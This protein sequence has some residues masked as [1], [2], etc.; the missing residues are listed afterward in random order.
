M[1]TN[2]EARA[3]GSNTWSGPRAAAGGVLAALMA[4]QVVSRIFDL[5]AET[6]DWSYR[7]VMVGATVAVAMRAVRVREQRAA[8]AVI[9]VGLAAW[10]A[11]DLWYL[12]LLAGGDIPY[13]SPSDA[14]YLVLYGALI[15]GMRMLNGRAAFSFALIVVLLGLAT[16]WSGLVFSEVV[17]GAAGGTTAV[18]TTL[19]Y[20][21]L[22]LVLVVA[23]LLA[24]AARGGRPGRVLGALA[25]GF[26]LMALADSAF[27]V[28]VA[29]GTHQDGTLLEPLWPAS[30]LCIAA[31][32][33]MDA[34]RDNREATEGNHVVEV[35]TG[36][37]IAVGVA[38]LALDHFLEV[39]EVTVGLAAITLIAAVAQHAVIQRDRAE[40]RAAVAAAEKLRGASAEAALDCIISIDGAGR[41][42]EWNGAAART[43][44]YSREDAVGVD[45]AQL[46]IPLEHREQH[47]RG[48]R[49][50]A[51]TGEGRML[52]SQIE[53]T[54]MHAEG[55]TFPVELMITQVRVDPP[56][57]TGFLR[58]I[59]DRR[60]R[61]G[62]NERLA[63]IVRSS[64]DAIISKGLD[65]IVT[66]WNGGAERLY[67]Y[68]AEEAIGSPLVGM[69][70]PAVLVHEMDALT[71]SVIAGESAALETQRRR[72]AGGL[73]DVALRAFAIRNLDGE[74]V[75]VCT[76]A[77]D[78][79]E[80]RRREED[81]RR[82]QEGRLWRSRVKTALAEGHL[83][84][85]GQPVVDAA[86][87]VTHHHELLLR[88]HLDGEVI[89][90]NHFLPPAENCELI[91]EIDRFAVETGFEIAATVPVAINLSAKSLQ[92]PLFIT[93]IKK[94]LGTR[95][96]A[97]NVI[98]EITETAAVENLEA[99]RGFVEELTAL[100]FGVALDD[101]GTGYGSFTYLK[102]LP[103]TELKIDIDFVRG[104]AQDPTDQRLVKS[105]ISVAQN[106]DMKTVAEGVEDQATLD[107]LRLLGVD[108]VQGYYI[109]HPAEMAVSTQRPAELAVV[110]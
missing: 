108:F 47:K 35:L 32:A 79:S 13:P 70:V 63:A 16:L 39:D 73:V 93:D 1:D 58:D 104:L 105:I 53:V 34:G 43:F 71:N 25:A 95:T 38:V 92:D 23:T 85:W 42:S 54:A 68:T 56:L 36:A 37:A 78:V 9:A 2:R 15:A 81:E 60:R 65:G 101:F 51:E 83:M 80:R 59:S 91:T 89:T 97:Q 110:E 98:F 40:A 14:L 46:I 4:L 52:N 29:T 62:E 57:F 45:L 30:A 10:T 61:E 74:I 27:V 86:T 82:D 20:P 41:V 84:F 107:L 8:W 50:V 49:R 21:L 99:A 87:G 106:F 66:A 96:L 94:A 44:G 76:S 48:L 33:W 103:V 22:D 26:L 67:G 24:V 5:G 100:G 109:G 18:A 31:A 72:K 7:A 11:G 17:E 12:V 3:T 6:A 55:H 19:A 28:Q 90:P 75:G 102:H 88:M 77:H 64:D 69:I